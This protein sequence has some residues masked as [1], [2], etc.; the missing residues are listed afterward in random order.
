MVM[1]K[2]PGKCLGDSSLS[3]HLCGMAQRTGFGIILLSRRCPP[4]SD[5][6]AVDQFDFC[7]HMQAHI[8][9]LRSCNTIGI[10]GK[11]ITYCREL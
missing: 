2:A 8:H 5:D 3:S 4:Y 7:F 10:G 1:G 11:S 9:F 6:F